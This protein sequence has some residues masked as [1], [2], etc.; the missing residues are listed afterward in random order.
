MMEGFGYVMT[1]IGA[2]AS[3]GAFM[4]FIDW[5]DQPKMSKKKPHSCGNSH[6]VRRV[7]K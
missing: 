4:S 1:V 5:I 6:A 3:A 7:S 2:F